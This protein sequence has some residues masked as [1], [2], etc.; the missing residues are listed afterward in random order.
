[1]NRPSVLRWLALA[2]ALLLLNSSLTFHNVWPT[3]GIRWVSELSVE[4]TALVFFL[5]LWSA[6]L[7]PPSERFIALLSVVYIV[8]ILGRYGE[9][10]A[11]ALYGRPVNLYWDS[12]HIASVVGMISRVAPTWMVI[13]FGV[14]LIVAFAL[15]Y[16]SVR[17]SLRQVI[18]A[19]YSR[20]TRIGLGVACGV[21]LAWFVGQRLNPPLVPPEP[22]FSIP[23]TKTY[24]AQLGLI[25]DALLESRSPQALPDTPPMDSGLS[26]LGGADVFVLFIE[27][28]GS[29][30]Y[31]R[32]EFFRR[33]EPARERLGEAVRDTRR[34]V[35][36][37]FVESPTF[38][39]ASWLA[40]LSLLSGIEVRDPNRYDLL[41]T[42][43]RETLVSTFARHGYRTVALMPGLR[44]NWPEGGF[45]GFDEIYGA[46]RLEYGG[47]EFGWWRIPDQFALARLDALEIEPRSRPP[48]LV[49]FTTISTHT[50]FRPTPPYQP[51]WQRVLSEQPFDAHEVS[52]SL[53]Q[54][55]DWTDIGPAYTDS[56]EYSL[57]TISGYLRQRPDRDFVLI[58]LGDHQ[59]P[60]V[61][62]GEGAS[63][64][65]PV[66]V[67][68]SR[69]EVLN[70]LRAS[71]FAPGLVPPRTA[72][73]RTHELTSLLLDAFDGSTSG[74]PRTP[75]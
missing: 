67:I 45:Y 56:V 38:G 9:V 46:P 73:S 41:M 50:P 31:D 59:P 11:P 68:T 48:L 40:H 24:S 61:V 29:V 13:A 65:V 32:P 64:D 70:A 75:R 72:I 34:E 23:V 19:L 44:Q 14:G 21:L 42:Q 5:A 12:Q 52:L 51:D 15:L 16:V 43:Q 60:A 69:M 1:M 37:A 18:D 66:H 62:S 57:D 74:E 71:G 36:S 54:A 27:S 3:I 10:T 58:V 35:V 8:F 26:A 63:W 30:T 55:P 22:R 33:L 4:L 25:R 7:R 53:A 39:G 28:Y 6:W 49:F 2:A 20:P 47:P 17:W